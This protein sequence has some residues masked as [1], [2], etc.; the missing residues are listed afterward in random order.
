MFIQAAGV[1]Q[2]RHYQ[3]S[4]ASSETLLSPHQWTVL[5]P[6]SSLVLPVHH[7][8]G[9]DSFD[10]RFS[11][12]NSTVTASSSSASSQQTLTQQ[13]GEQQRVVSE[14]LPQSITSSTV[15]STSSGFLQPRLVISSILVNT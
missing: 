9:K 3:A 7:Q 2:D 10:S 1:Y 11:R 14:K 8:A 12:V 6:A 15:D 5:S 4:S 13:Q